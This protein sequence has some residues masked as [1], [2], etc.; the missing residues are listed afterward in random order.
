MKIRMIF[1]KLFDDHVLDDV[2]SIYKDINALL[3]QRSILPKIVS[4]Y[5]AARAQSVADRA[6]RRCRLRR[7]FRRQ[8]GA[9][10][11]GV[12]PMAMGMPVGGIM[13]ADG[14]GAGYGSD[15]GGGEQDLFFRPAESCSARS[16][17]RD[18]QCSALRRAGS[19][20]GGM[21]SGVWPVAAPGGIV[22]IPG[23]PPIL[24]ASVDGICLEARSA[25]MWPVA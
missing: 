17:P 19:Q 23:F 14:G 7:S 2:R 13:S 4:A 9:V 8:R 21:P 11:A 1:H 15:A 3:I 24:G 18:G 16:V 6:L 20:A 25:S 22:Q 10:A 5:V 12:N